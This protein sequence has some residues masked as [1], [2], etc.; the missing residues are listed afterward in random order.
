ML[1]RSV[2]VGTTPKV[3]HPSDEQ[4][5]K[6][7]KPQQELLKI[8][9]KFDS[10]GVKLKLTTVKSGTGTIIVVKRLNQE[11]PG[12]QDHPKEDLICLAGSFRNYGFR[13]HEHLKSLVL[14]MDFKLR[15]QETTG[16]SKIGA[17]SD[18]R[19]SGD[20]QLL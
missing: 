15:I 2:A 20:S 10:E 9:W 7:T 1:S 3:K 8:R 4:A 17:K 16:L 5:W 19:S 11:G 13:P 14:G 6:G 12:P 18:T